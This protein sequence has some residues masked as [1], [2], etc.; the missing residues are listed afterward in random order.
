MKLLPNVVLAVLLVYAIA[1]AASAAGVSYGISNINTTVSINLNGS[2]HVNEAITVILPNSSLAQYTI[3][4]SGLNLT[5]SNWQTIVGPQLVRHIIN[6]HTGVYSFHLLPGPL[7]RTSYGGIAVMYMTYY[8]SNATSVNQ[9]GPRMLEFKFN[10]DVLNFAHGSGGVVLGQDTRFNILLP[11]SSKILSVYPLPDYPSGFV[12]NETNVTEIS[13][14]GGEPLYN[15]NL[16][17]QVKESLL[18]E[19]EDFFGSIYGAL[20][21]FTYIIV[22]V[23]VLLIIF[24]TYLKV[25]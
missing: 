19:V 12:L 6:P 1:S 24:Y 9:T 22:L 5:L 25:H 18:S 4:R 7:N 11:K 14:F 16:V 17:F 15:F 20:G 3:D 2:A 13:W 23:I 8:V 10:N 21:V